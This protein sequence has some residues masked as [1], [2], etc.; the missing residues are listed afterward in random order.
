ML[1]LLILTNWTV[2]Y[3]QIGIKD[4]VVLYTFEEIRL[5][6]TKLISAKECDTLLIL[7]GAEI[8]VLERVIEKKD[9]VIENDSKQLENFNS[10]LLIKDS[11]IVNL[12]LIIENDTQ[13][14]KWLKVGWI[15]TSA[16]LTGLLVVSLF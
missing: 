14:K 8:D 12:N 5:I 16:I 2:S 9:L 3:G 4:S 11:E 15:S 13:K 1:L 7:S 6:A 10:M